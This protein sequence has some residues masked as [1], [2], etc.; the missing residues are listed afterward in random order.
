MSSNP[1]CT[2]LV[3]NHNYGRFLTSCIKSAQNQTYQNIKIVVVD[4]A[5]T[6][7]SREIIEGLAD[8]D[9]RIQ[10]IYL[11]ECQ[12]ASEARNIGIRS[13]W[14]ETDYFLILDADDEAHPTKVEE[15]VKVVEMSNAIGAVYADYDIYNVQTGNTI[16]EF[17][18]PY[19]LRALQANCIVHSASLVSKAALDYIKEINENGLNSF[20]DKGLH[21]P[22]SADFI[23][24][25][26]DYLLWLLISEKFMFVHIPKPLSLVRVHGSNASQ[27][28]KV[29]K[30]WHKN[31]ERIQQ[32]IQNRRN[33]NNVNKA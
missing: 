30:V 28:E 14:D 12:G 26:E 22:A 19:S 2:V 23:G 5:S 4:D 9:F 1:R 10:P 29:N 20:Y 32:K 33:A 24:S 7:N 6:D 18:E 13:V 17:K 11:K 31:I 25:C 15:M 16:R 3:A 21:G 27:I 8:K